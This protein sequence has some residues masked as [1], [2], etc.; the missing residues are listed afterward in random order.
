MTKQIDRRKDSIPRTEVRG[1]DSRAYH[2]WFSPR[3]RMPAIIGEIPATLFGLLREI[4]SEKGIT[5]L[6]CEAG[7]DHVH[8]LLRPASG[9]PLARAVQLLKGIS[10]R[11]LHERF[12]GLQLDMGHDHFWQR[13]YGYRDVG[14]GAL[15]S[16]AEYIR[17]HRDHLPGMESGAAQ[18]S[19]RGR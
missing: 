4:A 3:R 19:A 18:F 2:V 15:R 8:L 16:V 14:P 17:K 13:G 12:P 1:L 9:M 5:L 6:E 11:R 10:S 7:Y